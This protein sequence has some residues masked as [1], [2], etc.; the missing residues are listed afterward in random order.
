MSL[1]SVPLLRSSRSIRLG[2]VS[3]RARAEGA[4]PRRDAPFREAERGRPSQSGTLLLYFPTSVD[5]TCKGSPEDIAGRSTGRGTSSPLW[6]LRRCPEQLP[7]FSPRHFTLRRRSR[8]SARG[9]AHSN[10]E[11]S[12]GSESGSRCMGGHA[13][14]SLRPHLP[15]SAGR[16]S[17]SIGGS[18]DSSSAANVGVAGSSP[19]S[20][21][22]LR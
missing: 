18:S 12:S 5:Q 15:R 7:G 3:D 14:G 1:P 8:P 4:L 21:S 17:E 9:R 22:T 20:S 16:Q 2:W 6:A 11:W 10:A 19:V 13:R